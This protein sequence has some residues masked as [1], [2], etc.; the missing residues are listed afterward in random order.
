M[1]FLAR[2]NISPLKNSRRVNVSFEAHQPELAATVV[3]AVLVAYI[4][5]TLDIA[6]WR[7]ALV[8]WRVS[9][10]ETTSS[11]APVLRG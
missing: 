7:P 3:K 10:T 1:A 11:V 9:R 5:Q 8:T 4:Q 2:L 6:F